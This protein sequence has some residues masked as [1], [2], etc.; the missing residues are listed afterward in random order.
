MGRK[1]ARAEAETLD[2]LHAMLG[3]L[4]ELAE[5]GQYHMLAYLIDMASIEAGDILRGRRASGIGKQQRDG[6]A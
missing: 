1:P 5:A 3:E 2:Y 4:R 6:A